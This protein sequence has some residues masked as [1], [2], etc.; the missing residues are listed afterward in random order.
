[1]AEVRA[2]VAG[3]GG[4]DQH[5]EH[6]DAEDDD[7]DDEPARHVAGAPRAGHSSKPGSCLAAEPICSLASVLQPLAKRAGSNA[8]P[9]SSG[10][11][12][13]AARR[14]HQ[15]AHRPAGRAPAGTG[16]GPNDGSRAAPRQRERD[17]STC[18]RRVDL[19]RTDRIFEAT[20]APGPRNR[21]WAGAIVDATTRSHRRG[22]VKYLS[23]VRLA[24]DVV[25]R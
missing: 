25:P 6:E 11:H 24:A 23:Q 1:M 14:T 18:P 2:P 5:H 10:L 22:D 20:W 3:A 21:N 19:G 16:T 13:N 8:S 17:L 9:G 4:I 12:S 15:H 7:E